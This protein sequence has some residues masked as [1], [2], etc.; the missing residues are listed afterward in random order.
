MGLLRG[1]Y[2][3]RFDLL[4][5]MPVPGVLATAGNVVFG[6]T[7]F[8]HLL[9]LDAKTGKLLWRQ[10]LGAPISYAVGGKQYITLATAAV[11]YTFAIPSSVGP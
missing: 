11:Q 3:W 1:D 6:G 2:R 10:Q 4:Q 7:A 8:G 5:G 9:G